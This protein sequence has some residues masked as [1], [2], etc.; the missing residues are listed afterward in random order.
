MN[1]RRTILIDVAGALAVLIF[2][3]VGYVLIEGWGAFDAFFMTITTVTTVGYGEVHPLSAVGKG[4]T[5]VLI[6]VG[7]SYFAYVFASLTGI[8]VG[9]QLKETLG[10]RKLQ[11]KIQAL[12]GHYIICGFG[13]IGAMVAAQIASRGI[14]FVVIETDPEAL[15]RLDET[16]YLY[17][18]GSATEEG[19]LEQAGI[20][21]AKGVVSAVRSDA[22]NVFIVLT[23]RDL[24]QD[25]FIL[26]RAEHEHSRKKLLRAGAD[27]VVLP[28]HIGARR[29]AEAI[30]RP[31]ISDFVELAV[32]GRNL[33]LS[34]EEVS[35]KPGAQLAGQTL[36][37]S[38]LRA[39]LDLLVVAIKRASGEMVFNPQPR[40][41][42]NEGDTLIV[43]GESGNLK[44]LEEIA[45]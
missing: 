31:A 11:K 36:I 37:D 19:V 5:S 44:R 26:S 40:E 16:G 27:K 13:R 43:L 29:M 15:V 28:Y 22:D 1:L 24:N 34:M 14:S 23:A 4:F 21:R 7:V 17:V 33:E 30:A 9:G 2:G 3:T 12:K 42:I 10:R 25:L 39:K 45:G 35:V 8:I 20:G 41:V 32:H 38:A 6:I 18:A